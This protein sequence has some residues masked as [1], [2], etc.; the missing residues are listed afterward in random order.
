MAQWAEWLPVHAVTLPT[1]TT[2]KYS[3]QSFKQNR[4]TPNKTFKSN[5]YQLHN[6]PQ[7]SGQFILFLFNFGHY[8][9]VFGTILISKSISNCSICFFLLLLL[10]LCGCHGVY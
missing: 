2:P 3:S 4:Q 1:S 10:F 6:R 5:R 7:N 8:I 9:H